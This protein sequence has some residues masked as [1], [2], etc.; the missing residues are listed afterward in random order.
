MD[1]RFMHSL[2]LSLPLA[3]MLLAILSVSNGCSINKLAI[4]KLAH[5]LSSGGTSFASDDDPELVRAA[6]PFSLKL[7]ESLLAET[8]DHPELLLAL[9]SGFTQFAYAFVQQEADFLEATDFSRAES[10]RT[11]AGKL[12]LRARD[13]GLRG[14]ELSNPGFSTKLRIRPMETV[15]SAGPKDL[16]LLY[17]TAAAWGSAIGVSKS[18]PHLIAE[19]VLVEA[20]IDRALAIDETFDRGA[21]HSFLISYEMARQGAEGTADDRAKVHFQ[22]AVALSHGLLASPFVAYAESVM[23]QTQDFKQFTAL[24][25]KALA[26]DPNLLPES[27]LVNLVFQERAKWLLN[28]ADELFLIS[29]VR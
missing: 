5:A 18:N 6:V 12:Y 28:H 7:M 20:L 4:N 22:Q 17:W 3:A 1:N 11:R 21:I 2:G 15:N 16:P 10:M 8:P 29:D 25:E 9:T 26:I 24:L 27:R 13:Y 23:V 14:L 19:Q